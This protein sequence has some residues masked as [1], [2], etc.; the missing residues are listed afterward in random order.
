M[1]MLNFFTRLYECLY[2]REWMP[3]WLLTPARRITRT[4]A[5]A[6]LPIALR[7]TVEKRYP[8]NEDIIV[9][10][11]SFPARIEDVWKVISC[12]KHQTLL[13]G[14]I[15]LWLSKDQFC[16]KNVLPTYLLDMEDDLFEI[17]LVEGDIQSHKKY[18]YAFKELK[19]KLIV[20][21]DDDIYYPPRMIEN[22]F[23]SYQNGD[24]DVI[25]RYGYRIKR[26][27]DGELLP[28][29]TWP[30]L[31]NE[32]DGEDVFFGS[33]GGTM[34][35]PESFYLEAFNIE[36]ARLL[37][38]L[39]DDIWLNAMARYSHLNIKMLKH[40]SFLPVKIQKNISLYRENQGENKND[41]QLHNLINHYCAK[42][43]YFK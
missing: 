7:K 14:K 23:Q 15:I 33:G 13:P 16:D 35:K 5:N 42:G 25:C 3:I 1:W 32:T 27:R 9:S 31:Y 36:L 38:P 41:I 8:R 34:L 37:T 24:G 12:M 4:I 2:Q 21:I 11:T 19:S 29:N 6:I 17:R 43:F 28:Y 26:D 20:L 30:M 39:A 10:L 18:Y 22:L 40:G